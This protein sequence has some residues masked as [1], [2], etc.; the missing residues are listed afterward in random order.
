MKS[1]TLIALSLI[2]SQSAFAGN[3]GWVTY[4]WRAFPG[5]DL[6]YYAGVEALLVKEAKRFCTETSE[7]VKTITNINIQIEATFLLSAND[8]KAAV[9]RTYPQVL[10]TALVECE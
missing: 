9:A 1:I 2:L 3:A 8:D 6:N 7:T 5:G 4:T 10:A